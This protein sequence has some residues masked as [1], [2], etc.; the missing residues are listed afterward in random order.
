MKMYK[1]GLFIMLS[2]LIILCTS[3]YENAFSQ[4]KNNTW[5]APAAADKLVNPL[6]GNVDAVKKGE[7]IYKS[8]CLVCHG[9]KG[10]GNGAAS[11]GLSPS[12]ANFLS[13]D[14]RNETD[15]AI[16]WKMSEGNP[17]MAAYKTL[18]T[19]TQRWQVVNYIRFL[20]TNSK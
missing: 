5:V 10:K 3:V 4:V 16:F 11:V 13:I 2:V 19:E 18:L 20:E 1:A 12:P 9:E 7:E 14:V 17:P 6:K 8:M 15:G